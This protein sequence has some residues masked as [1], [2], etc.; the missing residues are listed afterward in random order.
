[1]SN[2]PL[3]IEGQ[4]NLTMLQLL[5]ESLRAMLEYW[6]VER[7]LFGLVY[8]E[9]SCN[10]IKKWYPINFT[11]TTTTDVA[12]IT[13]TTT[14]N[15]HQPPTTAPAASPPLPPLQ[16]PPIPATITTTRQ[17]I[18][19][20]HEQRSISFIYILMISC[21]LLKLHCPQPSA[22]E[23]IHPNQLCKEVTPSQAS[24]NSL[25]WHGEKKIDWSLGRKGRRVRELSNHI[26]FI[27]R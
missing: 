15:G 22:E 21:S 25:K 24:E 23:R 19:V 8:K 16:T 11:T 20:Y 4:K 2:C 27:P 14:T 7:G 17:G 26:S 6:Y 1:M 3:E 5:P 18:A 10:K 13:T 12:T 9:E